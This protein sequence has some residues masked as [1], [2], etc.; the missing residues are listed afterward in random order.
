MSRERR[1]LSLELSLEPPLD[2]SLPMVSCAEKVD[3][4]LSC[5]ARRLL[6]RAVVVAVATVCERPREC[7]R[8]DVD[9]GCDS[10]FSK[11]AD[12]GAA[13]DLT[14]DSA[15]ML[16]LLRAVWWKGGMCGCGGR[17][18][19]AC[20]AVVTLLG[21]CGF[22]VG[23]VDLELDDGWLPMSC[24]V[25]VAA[26]A[27]ALLLLHQ[28]R[29]LRFTMESTLRTQDCMRRHT[30]VAICMAAALA[31]N[32]QSL[33]RMSQSQSSCGRSESTAE[34]PSPYH[35]PPRPSRG[36]EARTAFCQ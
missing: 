35:P 30:G 29:R 31:D 26:G 7:G 28:P 9:V 18:L 13:C 12:G 8:V 17:S 11:D 36:K 16:S 5:A 1:P 4:T 6:A 21:L 20:D 14:V 33:P 27:M 25:A 19:C 32:V 34:P 10:A 23:V 2:C 22:D 24:A 15:G 3:L